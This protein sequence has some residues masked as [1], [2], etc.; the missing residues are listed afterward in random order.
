M[1]VDKTEAGMCWAE[2]EVAMLLLTKRQNYRH[3]RSSL[4]LSLKKI[5]G[6]LVDESG[7]LYEPSRGVV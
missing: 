5:D 1:A 2:I 3:V 7:K 4:S 6:Q